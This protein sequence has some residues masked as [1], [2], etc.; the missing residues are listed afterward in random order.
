[1]TVKRHHL[2]PSKW[3]RSVIRP[4]CAQWQ[5]FIFH[6]AIPTRTFSF[7]GS[8]VACGNPDDISA[9]ESSA[10][11][12]QQSQNVYL[13]IHL[14]I[15]PAGVPP[16]LPSL[17]LKHVLPFWMI[18]WVSWMFRFHIK[19]PFIIISSWDFY[20]K[21]ME[22]LKS[23]K[24]KVKNPKK[25]YSPPDHVGFKWMWIYR[26]RWNHTPVI[27]TVPNAFVWSDG[28]MKSVDLM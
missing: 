14:W 5:G 13:F 3:R 12:N 20:A 4:H 19:S 23:K 25:I 22:Y 26:L 8:S 11:I 10:W 24:E 27:F 1:M 7:Q 6:A 21:P 16:Q 17:A 28:G 9:T 15:C 18:N 2:N